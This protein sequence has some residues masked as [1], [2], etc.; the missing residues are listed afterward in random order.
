M[1]AWWV[2]GGERVW[3]QDGRLH[4][5][6]DPAADGPRAATIWARQVIRGDVKVTFD[7][8][9]VSSSADANNI[10]LFLF[11]SDP[12]GKPLEAT[13]SQRADGAYN[14]YHA[15][16]G[17]ILT[18]VNEPAE[19][20]AEG[21]PARI[22]MRRCP[23]FNLLA[24]TRQHHSRSGRTYHFEIVRRAGKMTINVDGRPLLSADDPQPHREGLLGLR[25]F[26]T[27]LWWDNIRVESLP[28]NEAR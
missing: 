17:Y 3:V 28:M 6:A 1:K 2:E 4:V 21:G 22:R 7:A 20:A 10:N 19:G 12:A 11:Y 13:A 14:R 16:N 27:H 24:E 5:D 26:R 9:V 18:F 15:L 8:H 23:G 25:T